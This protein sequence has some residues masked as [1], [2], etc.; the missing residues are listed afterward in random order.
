M[1]PS[2]HVALVPASF[3]AIFSAVSASVTGMLLDV[4]AANRSLQIH[5][6]N[7]QRIPN[8]KINIAGVVFRNI[9]QA[10]NLSTFLSKLPICKT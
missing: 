10:T 2:E 8:A 1:K 6:V 7:N 5:L 9:S 4:V 3:A